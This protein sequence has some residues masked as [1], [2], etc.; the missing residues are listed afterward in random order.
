[1]T[2]AV[3]AR[4]LLLV[5]LVAATFRLLFIIW[6]ATGWYVVEQDVLSRTYFRQGY[7]LCA[8]YGYVREEMK[9]ETLIEVERQVLDGQRVTPANA[10]SSESAHFIPDMQHPPGM[11]I[12]VAAVHAAT[13]ARADLVVEVLGGLL[14]SLA[15]CLLYWLV[16]T[17]FSPRVG[18]VAGLVY[19]LYPPLVYISTLSRSPDG[20][21]PVFVLGCLSCVLL[22]TRAAE[23]R[24]MAWC[25]AGGAVLGLGSYFR[26]DYLLLPVALGFALWVY[27]RRFRQSLAAGLVLQATALLVLLPWAVRNHHYCGRWVFTSTCVG[28]ALVNG[29]AENA[30]PWGFGGLDEDRYKEAEA[31]GIDSPGSAEGD[32]FFRHKFW[33][34]VKD[35]PTG[36]F[37]AVMKRVP[38]AILAPQSFGFDNP[39]KTRRFSESRAEGQDRFGVVLSD[40]WYVFRAYWDWL[41]M[42]GV[43]FVALLCSLYMVVRERRR[44]GLMLLLFAPHLYAV[45]SHLPIYF[46]S[47]YVLPSIFCLLVGLAYVIARGWRDLPAEPG[48][49]LEAAACAT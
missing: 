8:G 7:A 9:W 13:G 46:E 25:V 22:A 47:R 49:P 16:A 28:W 33:E 42:G 23:W 11:A 38:M 43:A 41:L 30:N 37:A 15:A 1:M 24:R 20:F 5:G 48:R 2:S 17:F 18:F 45:G 3:T 12:L 29:L 40:P 19:A 35:N 26:P 32:E 31:A 4:R 34:A 39:C 10:T 6:G 44:F 21:L 14:D 36:Y 27:T